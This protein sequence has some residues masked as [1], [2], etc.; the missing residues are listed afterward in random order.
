M[1][2][3]RDCTYNFEL[4]EKEAEWLFDILSSADLV[5]VDTEDADEQARFRSDLMVGLTSPD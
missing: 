1:K 4:N 3:H 2:Y 5:D